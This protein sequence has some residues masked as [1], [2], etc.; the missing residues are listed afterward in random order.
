MSIMVTGGFG[1]VGSSVVRHLVRSGESV[2][3]YDIVQRETAFLLGLDNS[4]VKTVVGDTL[5]LP[6]LIDAMT[7]NQAE[8][9]IHTA[10]P[11]S[12]DLLARERPYQ[13]IR[14]NVETVL[15]CVEAARLAKVRRFIHVGSGAVYGIGGEPAYEDMPLLP[16]GGTYGV[17]KA[18]GDMVVSAYAAQY[19]HVTEYVTARIVFVYGPGRAEEATYIGPLV[20]KALKTHEV[21]LE[22][23]GEYKAEFTHVYD[24][25]KGLCLIAMARRLKHSLYNIG[26]GKQYTLSAVGEEIARQIP[27]TTVNIGPGLPEGRSVRRVLDINRVTKE[28]GYRPDYDLAAGISSVKQWLLTGEYQ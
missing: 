19:G 8:V 15:N 5:D 26:T 9:V 12:N 28:C 6:R 16:T 1:L 14:E 25:A 27:G 7:E 11:I 10:A 13:T 3:I 23:G 20:A 22:R 17:S 4:N 24:V 21:R 18:A 2:T